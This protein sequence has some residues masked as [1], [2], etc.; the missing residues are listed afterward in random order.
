[1]LGFGPTKADGVWFRSFFEVYWLCGVVDGLLC[2]R[3]LQLFR[4]LLRQV[5]KA[6]PIWDCLNSSE[7]WSFTLDL[8]SGKTTR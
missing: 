2:S 1:M 7:L 4:R 3:V 8:I 5:E 6:S